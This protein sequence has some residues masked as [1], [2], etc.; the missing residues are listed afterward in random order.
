MQSLIEY[1]R[2]RSEVRTEYRNV[3]DDKPASRHESRSNTHSSKDDSYEVKFAGSDTHQPLHWPLS[4]KTISTCL[5]F[6]LVFVTGWASAS[7]SSTLQRSRARFHVWQVP[8]VLS[9][10]LYLFGVGTGAL[11]AGPVSQI[12]GRNPLYFG[13]GLLYLLAL[14]GS[15]LAPNYATRIIMRMFA[16]FFASPAMTNYGGS[17]SDMYETGQRS[18]VWPIFSL[19]TLLGMYAVQIYEKFVLTECRSINRTNSKRV[20]RKFKTKL[21]LDRLVDINYI[22]ICFPSCLPL[23]TRDAPRYNRRLES[24]TC[25]KGH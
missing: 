5:L 2:I 13:P 18:I 23:P 22:W 7:D 25:S 1:R 6:G 8:E 10:A 9:T 21:A 12:V 4:K 19:S 20:D 14:F 24:R 15:A 16:G 17:L 3:N 11:F